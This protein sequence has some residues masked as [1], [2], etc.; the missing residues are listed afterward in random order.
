MPMSHEAELVLL[1]AAIL[2]VTALLLVAALA[3]VILAERSN[4]GVADGV[5]FDAAA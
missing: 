5:F 1:V 4:E 2:L 3:A